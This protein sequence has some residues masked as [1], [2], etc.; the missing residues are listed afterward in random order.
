LLTV[1]TKVSQIFFHPT[2]T[3]SEQAKRENAEKMIRSMRDNDVVSFLTTHQ[4]QLSTLH[5]C[6]LTFAHP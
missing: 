4:K 2:N 1:A 3:S 6:C 5:L